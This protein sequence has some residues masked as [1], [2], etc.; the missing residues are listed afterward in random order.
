MTH[1]D[2]AIIG[3]GSGNSLITPEWDS[4]KVAVIDGG[5]FGGTCLN[6]GCIPTKMFVYPAQLAAVPGEAARLGVDQTLDKVHWQGIRDRIFTRI[7]AISAGGRRYRAEE[8]DNVTLYDRHVRFISEHALETDDGQRITADQ[9]VV[10]AGSR[11]V[12]P[13]IP[14]INLPQVHTSDTVMRIPDLPDRILIIGG[15][16]I[17]AEFGFVFS[18]FGAQVT[19]A[20]R[21]GPLLRALDATVAERFTEAASKEWDVRLD[22]QVT[23]LTENPDG[24][25]R[26]DLAGPQGKATLDV[27][28]VLVATGR[29]PNTDR[30]DVAA[31]GFD[32]WPD[33]RLAVDEFQRV[34]KNGAPVAGVWGLGDVSSDF[35]LKH[36]AN[37]EA[38]TVAHNLLHPGALRASDHRFVPSA[39]FSSPQIASVGMTEEEACAD[40]EARGVELALAVQEYGSTA[41]GWAMEDTTGF[42]K[43]LAEK[44]S[45]RL[46]GAHI[47]GHEASMLI[48]PLIQAMSFGLDAHTM[49]SGQYWIHPALTEVVENALLSL[50]TGKA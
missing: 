14:G 17:A 31:A 10:A 30:L 46:L 3:S 16:Y 21:S 27:D 5:T 2:L 7:D 32:Q 4:K 47:M 8:L 48:Q 37:H 44:E 39:V 43:L 6:V 40:T 18:A 23:A 38:R 19:M 29:V 13:D 41:Y 33:G 42:V 22:T 24:S 12:L 1:F 36:V 25:V 20:A 28:L 26:A 45:G 50:K 34:L 15:G 35:Q 9:I 49:A 11:P